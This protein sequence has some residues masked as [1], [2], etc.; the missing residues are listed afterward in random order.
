MP[1]PIRFH[2]SPS[3]NRSSPDAAR[4]V[5]LCRYA[6][7]MGVESVHVPIAGDLSQALELALVAG[8]ETKRVRFRIGWDLNG[9]LAS[10]LGQEL[11]NAW[12]TLRGRLVIHMS[13]DS[14]DAVP[15]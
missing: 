2:W 7:M 5:D 10:L 14:D 4:F 15:N 13:F 3:I 8:A 12:A 9:V 6:E 1:F 11:K